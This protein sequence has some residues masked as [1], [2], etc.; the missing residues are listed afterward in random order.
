LGKGSLATG[1]ELS[2]PP[3]VSELRRG[4]YVEADLELVVFPA[5]AGDYWGPNRDFREALQ[6]SADTWE[7]V[8]N[9]AARN[10][11]VVTAK[12]GVVRENYPL[13][14]ELDES[15]RAELAVDGGLGFVPIT[16]TGVKEPRD[17]V[18]KVDGA[19]V[20]QSV[21]GNDFWQVDADRGTDTWVLT[22]NVPL[23]PGMHA[24]D[25]ATA[26]VTAAAA[27]ATR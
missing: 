20:D 21:H 15:G 24:V 4:D 12:R 3:D 27:A 2:V 11:L 13:R 16:F 23:R 26:S 22:L 18:F 8:H 17:F 9:E 19:I 6:R 5:K 14:V 1:L 7:L 25:F 10:G